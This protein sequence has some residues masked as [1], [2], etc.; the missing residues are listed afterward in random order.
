MRGE[1]ESAFEESAHKLI[2]Q[3]VVVRESDAFAL[4]GVRAVQDGGVN[5]DPDPFAL[6]PFDD[7]R[8]EAEL[9]PHPQGT[10]R[11]DVEHALFLAHLL[12]A[13]PECGFGGNVPQPQRPSEEL[14]FAKG[15]GIWS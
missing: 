2:P 12:K 7:A 3:N 6:V 14:V 13:L 4:G 9:A 15:P 5:V 11:K 8:L 10:A 1:H